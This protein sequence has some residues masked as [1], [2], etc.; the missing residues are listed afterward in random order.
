MEA[1]GGGSLSGEEL[2]AS[3]EETGIFD[4]DGGGDV[5]DLSVCGIE[6]LFCVEEFSLPEKFVGGDAA[7]F[8]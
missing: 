7:F 1:I 2:E 5:F 3:A 6:E 4:A 8:F